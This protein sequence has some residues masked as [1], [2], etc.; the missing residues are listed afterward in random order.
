MGFKYDVEFCSLVVDFVLLT[1]W[2]HA[3]W[4]WFLYLRCTVAIG[5]VLLDESRDIMITC[6]K[7]IFTYRE[8][9]D[10]VFVSFRNRSILL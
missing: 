9:T 1:I 6:S 7:K 2:I 8:L 3:G 4:I 5:F 10:A